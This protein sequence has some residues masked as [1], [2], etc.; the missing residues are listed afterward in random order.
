MIYQTLKTPSANTDFTTLIDECVS[1]NRKFT[2]MDINTGIFSV[3]VDYKLL[4]N[5]HKEYY[6]IT[7]VAKLC[8]VNYENIRFAVKSGIL[9]RVDSELTKGTA[10]YIEK[11][12]ANEFN[13]RYIFG[14]CIAKQHDENPT[15]FSEKI[16]SFGVVPVSG[17]GIDGGL[18]YLFDRADIK[19]INID[20]IINAQNYPTLTGRKKLNEKAIMSSSVKLSTAAEALGV[21]LQ[22]TINLQKQGFLYS[23]TSTKRGLRVTKESLNKILKLINDVNLISIS[24]STEQTNET[25]NSFFW[26]WIKSGFIDYKNSGLDKYISKQDLQ[27]VINFKSKYISAVE[28]AKLAGHHRSYLPNLEKQGLIKHKKIFK[29]RK[30]RIKFYDRDEVVRLI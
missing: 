7:E 5:K 28:A 1:G 15:N 16:M 24:E 21:T 8:D 23:E 9:K 18:T 3:K 13:Q 2:T 30:Y 6:S 25:E 12:E 29:N 4:S 11:M 14:G 27:K 20:H 17:P 19:E 26:T 22:Q 10:I